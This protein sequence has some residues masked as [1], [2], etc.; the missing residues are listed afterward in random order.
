[1]PAID[2]SLITPIQLAYLAAIVGAIDFVFGVLAAFRTGTFTAAR[3]AD[4]LAN[5]VLARLI[6][7]YGLALIGTQI[8]SVFALAVGG[9]VLYVGETAASL[10]A[11]LTT[12]AP[13]MPATEPT[14]TPPPL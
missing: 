5:H 13:S 11:S 3:V 9:L 12:M 4:V 10:Q 6:P 2:L 8:P 7:I 1:M 14:V